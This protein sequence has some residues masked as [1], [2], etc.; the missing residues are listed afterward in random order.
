M[1][2]N[3]ESALKHGDIVISL[4]YFIHGEK[5]YK[6]TLTTAVKFINGKPV[7]N[8]ALII[9][10][11]IY[12]MGDYPGIMVNVPKGKSIYDILTWTM[13]NIEESANLIPH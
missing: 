8:F 7:E 13:K 10:S 12:P 11:G 6:I 9:D 2:S 3:W 4:P 5:G 1:K